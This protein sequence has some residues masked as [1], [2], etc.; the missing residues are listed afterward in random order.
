[1]DKLGLVSCDKGKFVVQTGRER[2]RVFRAQSSARLIVNAPGSITN[3][4]ICILI[5]QESKHKI[6]ATPGEHR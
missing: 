5:R 1:M 6:P 4:A 3:F 2:L